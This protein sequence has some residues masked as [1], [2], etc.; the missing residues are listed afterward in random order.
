VSGGFATDYYVDAVNGSDAN[1]GLA[2]GE[3][4]AKES[5]RAL[6]AAYTIRSGD[7]VHAAA[8]IYTNGV[9]L[10]NSAK[11]RLVVPAGVEV[12]G[13]GADVTTIE[14]LAHTNELG[15]TTLE[16]SPWGCGENALRG[17]YL[18]NNAI[19]RNITV[20]VFSCLI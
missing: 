13:A 14:G 5:F 17:V 18:Y 11:F 2:P 8:G 19:L 20:T 1:S 4:N 15:E 16:A 12:I 3:G 9:M 6:F 7:K 10:V